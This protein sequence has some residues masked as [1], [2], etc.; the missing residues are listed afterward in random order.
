MQA[1]SMIILVSTCFYLIISVGLFMTYDYIYELIFFLLFAAVLL[2][3]R[4]L[5]LPDHLHEL[6]PR[7]QKFVSAA[8][9]PDA[10]IGTGTKDPKVI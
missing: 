7:N 5:F 2:V 9:T 4:L 6:V 3:K 8:L 1:N 10:E